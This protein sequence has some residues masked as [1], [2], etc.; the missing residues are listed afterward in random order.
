MGLPWFFPAK[1]V[2]G[3]GPLR[4]GHTRSLRQRW[5]LYPRDCVAG[6]EGLSPPIFSWSGGTPGVLSE[7]PYWLVAEAMD[8][9]LFAL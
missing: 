8:S 4:S 1:G 7:R 5:T 6:S 2:L 9:V 3:H